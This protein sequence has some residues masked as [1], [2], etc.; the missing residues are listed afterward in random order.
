MRCSEIL[1]IW[2]VRAWSWPLVLLWHQT[3]R[4][5]PAWSAC[6]C[7]LNI[8]RTQPCKNERKTIEF[9]NRKWVYSERITSTSVRDMVRNITIQSHTSAHG[10]G[11]RPILFLSTTNDHHGSDNDNRN[12]CDAVSL[13]F[14]SHV[15]VGSVLNRHCESKFCQ[16]FVYITLAT[17]AEFWAS[18]YIG[19]LTRLFLFLCCSATK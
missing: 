18:H 16:R 1:R 5:L 14:H 12:R 6:K 15:D 8:T 9:C 7:A 10:F 19:T 3:D 17:A 4:P 2:L 11:F 13:A